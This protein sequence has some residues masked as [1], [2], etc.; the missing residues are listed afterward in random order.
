M[1]PKNIVFIGAGNVA[2]NLAVAYKNTGINIFQIYSRMEINAIQL[3]KKTGASYT[4]KLSSVAD[5]ADLY[6]IAVSD[7]IL[8]AIVNELKIKNKFVVHTSGFHS[9]DVLSGISENYGVLYP[10]QTFS[11]NRLLDFTLIPVCIEANSLENTTLLESIARVISSDIKKINSV[12]RKKIHL[13]AVFA[14]NFTN[15]MYNIAQ[16]ILKTENVS[17]DII[18]PLLIETANKILE[19]NPSDAQTGPARRNDNMIIIEHINMLDEN[20]YR[21]LY[22]IISENISE[23]YNK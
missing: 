8:P 23:I 18:K 2:T 15:Y 12:K 1:I 7:T 10:L 14:C 3:A 11:K 9:I 16:D 5:D 21:I 6:I 17:F 19:Q 22:K 13:A 20:K 4:D